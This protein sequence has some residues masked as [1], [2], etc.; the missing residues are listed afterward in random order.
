M[1]GKAVLCCGIALLLAASTV[2]AAY[3]NIVE[4]RLSGGAINPLFTNNGFATTSAKST[5][6]APPGGT[7]SLVG[8]GCYYA[9]DTTP[10]KTGTYKFTPA[11]D[12]GGYYNVYATWPT[13]AYASGIPAPTWTVQ[14]AGANVVIALAQT[15]GGNAWNSLA[16][17]VKLNAST[18]YTTVVAT[19]A[20]GVSNK[21]TYADSVAWVA[22]TPGAPTNTAPA[23]MAV[24]IPQTGPGNELSWAAGAYSSFFDVFLDISST[25][26]TKVGAD[27]TGTSFDP[28]ALELLPNQTYYWKV[29]AKNVD[30]S[31]SG[32][33]WS[34]TTTPEPATMALLGLG[35]LF[36][37][38]RR[39]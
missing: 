13:N 26:T 5:A 24:G 7:G 4:S 32:A 19:A 30:V 16:T 23:D 34:F 28:D 15:S 17:G 20:T 31:T 3:T 38:R 37:R 21:R 22:A 9:G 11:A 18:L 36:L 39:A 33:V 27:L 35:A 6:G 25:P 1:K 29:V 2:Q 14:N 12:K 8:T 10:A